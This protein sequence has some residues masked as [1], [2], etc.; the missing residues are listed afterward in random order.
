MLALYRTG[1]QTEALDAYTA[2]RARLRDQLGLEPTAQLRELQRR[3]LDHDSG[4]FV[5]TAEEVTVAKLPS[6]PN[7]LLGR[8]WDSTSCASSLAETMCGCS[9]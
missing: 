5:V 3:I 8:E 6:S 2:I 4:L 9:S 7:R 1:R